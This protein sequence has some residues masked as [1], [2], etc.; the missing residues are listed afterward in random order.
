M[1][2]KIPQ[3]RITWT[4]DDTENAKYFMRNHR[5]KSKLLDVLIPYRKTLPQNRQKDLCRCS[6]KM[7]D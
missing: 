4:F 1:S 6:H 5:N 7:N 3:S 2:L